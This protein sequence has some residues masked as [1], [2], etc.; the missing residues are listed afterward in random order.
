[1]NGRKLPEGLREGSRLD[2]PLYT[3]STKAGPG[4][5]DE[6][7]DEDEAAAVVGPEYADQI[8][9]LSLAMYRRAADYAMTRGIVLADTKF[10]L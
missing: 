6:N 3:P 8:K 7:I 5:H 1:M 2:P 9:A 4:E 10:E